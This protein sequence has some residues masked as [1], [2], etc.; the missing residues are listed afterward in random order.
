MLALGAHF[1]IGFGHH[2]FFSGVFINFSDVILD[3]ISPKSHL[4]IMHAMA[5]EGVLFEP[6]VVS[7]FYIV[8]ERNSLLLLNFSV[9]HFAW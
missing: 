6:F 5:I 7:V 1:L 3:T 8:S 9:D 4:F 2:M